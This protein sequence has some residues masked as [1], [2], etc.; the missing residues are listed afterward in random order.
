M[1]HVYIYMKICMFVSVCICIYIC[2]HTYANIYAFQ[3]QRSAACQG[4]P[5]HTA[6]VHV[7]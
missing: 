4:L 1:L 7:C 2:V 6:Y 3:L 5:K